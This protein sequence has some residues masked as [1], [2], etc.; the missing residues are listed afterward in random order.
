MA[1]LQFQFKTAKNF[2]EKAFKMH[3][4]ILITV[5]YSLAKTI[6][7]NINWKILFSIDPTFVCEVNVL[8]FH[9]FRV[10]LCILG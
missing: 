1:H 10:S 6:E 7:A 5:H 9:L 3:L 2:Y 4:F 8:C